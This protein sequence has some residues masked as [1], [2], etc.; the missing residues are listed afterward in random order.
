M[1]RKKYAT[2]H[3]AAL[4]KVED[5]LTGET[6]IIMALRM[7]A[8][9]IGTVS[10][11]NSKGPDPGNQRTLAHPEWNGVTPPNFNR[12]ESLP[13]M[14]LDKFEAETQWLVCTFLWDVG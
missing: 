13:A 8:G 9:D 5:A 3:T 7:T 11:E 14:P 12:V 1:V 2:S 4:Q 10:A 6:S